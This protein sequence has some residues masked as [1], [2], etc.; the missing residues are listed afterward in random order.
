MKKEEY[1]PLGY[2]TK[3]KGLKGE[4]QL[5]FEVENPEQYQN[6]ESVF[7]E[8]NKKPVPFFI[9]SIN[10]QKSI[11]YIYFEDVDHIDKA[12]P[13]VKKSVFIKTSQKPKQPDIF[14]I[15]DLKG[16]FMIDK[17]IG[18]MG[19][20]EEILK[21][22]Q[23]NIASVIYQNKEVLIPLVDH[24]I[25]GINIDQKEITVDLPEGLLDIYID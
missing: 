8:I 11:A 25:T 4:V 13:L 22:P 7:I 18:E 2:I 3:T 14:K 10:I 21:M 17:T 12:T 15:E 24:F 5:F 1:F 19:L 16:F 20:I 23:Q 6:L 9:S